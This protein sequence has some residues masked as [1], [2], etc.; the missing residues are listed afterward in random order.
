M[1]NRPVP[2]SPHGRT[3][4]DVLLELTRRRSFL[5]WACLVGWGLLAATSFAWYQGLLPMRATK[6]AGDAASQY[7]HWSFESTSATR[8]RCS[9]AAMHVQAGAGANA[10]EAYDRDPSEALVVGVHGSVVTAIGCAGFPGA[11]Q[12][13]VLVAAPEQ[14]SAQNKEALLRKLLNAELSR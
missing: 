1:A 2:P 6:A 10:T 11:P 12:S 7:L 13:L 3:S 9:A 5:V 8:E 4:W 14:T